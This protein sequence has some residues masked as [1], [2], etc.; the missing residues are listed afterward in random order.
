[1]HKAPRMCSYV[2]RSTDTGWNSTCFERFYA[3]KNLFVD[4]LRTSI[5]GREMDEDAEVLMAICCSADISAEVK[6]FCVL[7]RSPEP[8]Y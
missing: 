5:K 7:R 8:N 1:M 2:A 6:I 4:S 3:T